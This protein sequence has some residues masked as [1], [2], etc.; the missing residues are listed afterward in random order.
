MVASEEAQL[1]WLTTQLEL[2]EQLGEA[3]YLAQQLYE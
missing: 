3:N 1:D 2:I